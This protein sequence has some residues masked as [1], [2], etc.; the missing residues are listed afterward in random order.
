VENWRRLIWIFMLLMIVMV[1]AGCCYYPYR[2]TIVILN[3]EPI[4]RYELVARVATFHAE[5]YAETFKGVLRARGFRFELDNDN[6]DRFR[7]TL[8][9]AE[10]G[11]LTIEATHPDLGTR[12]YTAYG[13]EELIAKTHQ[14]ITELKLN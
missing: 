6:P 9:K 11:R 10:G 8:Y 4:K 12:S 2:G 3:P 7:F 1:S 13:R 14:A 5:E